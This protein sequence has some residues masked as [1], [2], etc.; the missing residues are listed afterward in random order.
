MTA[1]RKQTTLPLSAPSSVSSSIGSDDRERRMREGAASPISFSRYRNPAGNLSPTISIRDPF[2]TS[3]L[4][5]KAGDLDTRHWH[6]LRRHIGNKRQ[7]IYC[8]KKGINEYKGEV[9]LPDG[10]GEVNQCLRC[11]RMYVQ[12]PKPPKESKAIKT[13]TVHITSEKQTCGST[14]KRWWLKYVY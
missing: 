1:I 2:A 12:V 14:W 4:H 3:I 5:A 11:H 10:V 8:K 7:C 6:L 9:F 13:N